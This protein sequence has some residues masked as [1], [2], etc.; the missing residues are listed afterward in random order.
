MVVVDDKTESN[1]GR[2]KSNICSVMTSNKMLPSSTSTTTLHDDDL[3]FTA[4]VATSVAII[5]EWTV[6]ATMGMIGLGLWSIYFKP[7]FDTRWY[8][9]PAQSPMGVFETMRIITSDGIVSFFPKLHQ[10]VL[11]TRYC[12]LRFP[13]PGCPYTISIVDTD[14]TRDILN[15]PTTIKAEGL[16]K[17][18]ERVTCGKSQFFTSNGHRFHHARKAMAP[19]FANKHLA[20]MNEVTMAKCKQWMNQRLD[21][22]AS[23][24]E[25][26]DINEEMVDLALSIILEAAFEY[27]MSPKERRVL[28]HAV[29]V[30][31]REF[32][33]AHP[34]KVMFGFLFPSVWH[35]T[36]RA[37]EL[38]QIAN[39]IMTSYRK[40]PRPTKGTVIDLIMSNPN[41][42][43]DGERAA[44]V[45]D[46]IIAGHETSSN[47]MTMLLL[48]LAR[49]PIEQYKLQKEL[50]ELDEAGRP[51]SGQ[52]K[53]CIRESM[54][55]H[56]VTA[57]G[58][59]RQ[60]GRDYVVPS[61]DPTSNG[62]IIIPKNSLVFMPIICLFHNSDIFP[63]HE[64]FL[65]ARWENP[66][67]EMK[68]A[69]M[70][71]AI[72]NRNCLGQALAN[73]EM[74]SILSQVC[75]RYNF[76]VVDEGSVS[77][78]ISLKPV[79]VRLKATKI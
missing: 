19:A 34:F 58:P 29:H 32:V 76:E 71:F 22:F 17:P 68:R 46:L 2:R 53:S 33:F 69:W 25:I 67:E 18:F 56:P 11:K 60:V 37:R 8:R 1:L 74:Q 26:I 57:P 61:D 59:I 38:M 40:N 48:E 3:V 15:D 72:G 39:N 24:G 79:G 14:L 50:R 6:V 43:D 28:L 77:F 73:C 23:R 49:N 30:T 13:V 5:F 45:I 9:L 21:S 78:F 47:S 4:V 31:L 27:D 70:P 64:R 63:D 52:L 20:R 54:R 7:P 41:Y 51:S 55:L 75:A 65:P 62:T 35:A 36:G 12:R 44:D 10:Q 66:T 16:V 42:N